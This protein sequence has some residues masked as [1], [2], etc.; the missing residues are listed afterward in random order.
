MIKIMTRWAV[1][2]TIIETEL[3]TTDKEKYESNPLIFLKNQ[4]KF[5]TIH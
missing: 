2:E 4:I 3:V 5:L 1:K